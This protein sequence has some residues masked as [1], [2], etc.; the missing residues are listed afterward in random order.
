[1]PERNGEAERLKNRI[2][3]AIKVMT[4]CCIGIVA[5]IA[6]IAVFLGVCAGSGL[7]ESNPDAIL[8]GLIVLVTVALLLLIGLFAALIT[9]KAGYNSLKKIPAD[10][11][12]E[13]KEKT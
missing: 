8:I 1:M 12:E 10:V 6:A 11:E 3:R 5:V 2:N 4:G 13:I 7:K 9:A